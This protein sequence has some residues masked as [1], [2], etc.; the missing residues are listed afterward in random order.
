MPADSLQ[1]EGE[2]ERELTSQ[3]FHHISYFHIG[4][5]DSL[6]RQTCRKGTGM[7]SFDCSERKRPGRNTDMRTPNT[8]TFHTTTISSSKWESWL[9]E[10]T[11]Q[12]IMLTD[13]CYKTAEEGE[14]E[15]WKLTQC[16]VI[17]EYTNSGRPLF[18]EE[19]REERREAQWGGVDAAAG[20]S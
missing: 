14:G 16:I 2:E 5:G 13:H 12:E 1:R 8:V 7:A 3:Q 9:G 17:I 19:W 10:V 20:C 18:E 4:G 11:R 6:C 15:W